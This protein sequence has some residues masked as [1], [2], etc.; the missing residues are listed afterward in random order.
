MRVVLVGLAVASLLGSVSGCATVIRGTEQ[1][2]QIT[3]DPP[4]ARASLGTGQSC[5][6]PCSVNVS[7]STSTVVTFEKEGC[8][9]QM[10]S[11]FPTIAAA[12]VVLGGVIDYGTGAVYNLQPNPVVVQLRCG[13]EASAPVSPMETQLRD[14]QSLMDKGLITQTEYEKKRQSILEQR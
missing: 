8:E 9:R 1:A 5:T 7:R 2:L 11:V 12:G 6:T 14:L 3:S 10:A 4:G 13:V